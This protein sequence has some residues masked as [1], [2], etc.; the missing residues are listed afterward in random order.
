M[1]RKM[2]RKRAEMSDRAK[3]GE[4]KRRM[5]ENRVNLKDRAQGCALLIVCPFVLLFVPFLLFLFVLF[6]TLFSQVEI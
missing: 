3:G 1:K 4:L 6:A 5:E 2:E